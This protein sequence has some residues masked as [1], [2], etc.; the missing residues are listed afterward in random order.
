MRAFG[1]MQKRN[2][3]RPG[4]EPERLARGRCYRLSSVSMNILAQLQTRFRTA[5]CRPGWRSAFLR[6]TGRTRGDGPAEPGSEIRRLS[7]QLRDAAE[8]QAGPPAAR[9]RD[10]SREPPRHRRDLRAPR[11]RRAGLHQSAAPNGLAHAAV[12]RRRGRRA[13]GHRARRE[14]AQLRRRLFRPERRQTDARRPHPLDRHRRQPLPHPQIPRPHGY[15]RQSHRR[16]GHPVRDDYLWLQEF[17]RPSSLRTKS[18]QRIG[19]AVSTGESAGRV[20]RRTG[21]ITPRRETDRR[22]PNRIDFRTATSRRGQERQESGKGRPTGTRSTRRGPRRIRESARIARRGEK[23]P[24]ARRGRL[25]A[26]RDRQERLG[27]DGQAPLGR[28]RK[29][30]ALERI[31]SRRASSTSNASIAGSA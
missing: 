2:L 8:E 12:D 16:L 23:R 28:C 21:A 15:R 10:R 3:Q 1:G 7:G 24:P 4:R 17:P 31:P 27:R 25:F 30:R 9:D 13:A 22:G 19:P 18:S 29:P 26:S 6:R 20:L 11:D 5:T 14:A